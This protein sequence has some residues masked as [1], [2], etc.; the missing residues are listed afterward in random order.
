MFTSGTCVA[1]WLHVGC[2]WLVLSCC[3]SPESWLF[4]LH[5]A[6]LTSCLITPFVDPPLTWYMLLPAAPLT[7]RARWWA[8][9]ELGASASVCSRGCT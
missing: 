7:W 4:A 3:R 1:W 9:W 8:L 6:L 2:L 5:S